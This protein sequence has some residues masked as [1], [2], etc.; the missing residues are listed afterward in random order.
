MKN[1]RN[2]VQ[3]IGNLG[4]NP[5]INET[6]NGIKYSKISL[7]TNSTYLNKNGEKVKETQWHPVIL[8]G[9]KAEFAS[10]YIEKGQEI[11]IE[12]SLSYR[13][14]DDDQGNKRNVFEIIGN[15]ILLL[16]R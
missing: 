12:G 9:K 15:E 1:L 14:Y 4:D 7:A 3:I 13:S 2:R 8:W 11:C 5:I 10:S 6:S 16:K